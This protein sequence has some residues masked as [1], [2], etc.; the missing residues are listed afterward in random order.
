[1]K[2]Q[3]PLDVYRFEMHEI[4]MTD[5]IRLLD[6]YRAYLNIVDAGWD[7]E[8]IDRLVLSYSD[9]L[10]AAYLSK[11]L[12]MDRPTSWVTKLWWKLKAFAWDL[13]DMWEDGE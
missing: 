9:A 5:V 7:S 11:G 8:Q 2:L 4:A 6:E 1:M 12:Q 13:R 10:W 3:L